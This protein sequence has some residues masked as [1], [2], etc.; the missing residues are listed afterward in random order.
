MEKKPQGENEPIP[1]TLSWF[2]WRSMQPPEKPQK[3]EQKRPL[4]DD[5]SNPGQGIVHKGT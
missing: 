3:K 4:R 5:I 1:G 2:R